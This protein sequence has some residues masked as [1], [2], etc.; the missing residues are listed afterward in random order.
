MRTWF[1]AVVLA[2]FCAP[3]F[4]QTIA[5]GHVIGNGTSAARSATDSTMTGIFD[6]AF[7]ATNTNF[8]YRSSGTWQCA[9]TLP[10]SQITG[11]PSFVN[12]T[13]TTPGAV[14]TLTLTNTPIP[15]D[16]KQLSIYF[17]GVTQHPS[18]WS[19]NLGNG[20]ITFNTTIPTSVQEVFAAWSAPI[21][22]VG[23]SSLGSLTGAV[24]AGLGLTAKSGDN[25]I[26][27]QGAVTINV[28]LPPYNAVDD[29]STN[30]TTAFQNAITDAA[31]SGGPA[32]I[33]IPPVTSGGGCYKVGAI[34]ATKKSNL[35]IRGNGDASLLEPV[36]SSATNHIWWDISG[37]TNVTFENF[38]VQYDGATVPAILFL[39]AAV[40]GFTGD[41]I[42]GIRFRQVN[43][44]AQASTALVYVY[45]VSWPGGTHLG[46]G[47]FQCYDSTWVQRKNGSFNSNPSLRNS[48][49]SLNGINSASVASDYQTLTV[50]QPGNNS[51]LLE[52]CNL[53]DSPSGFGSGVTDNNAALIAVTTGV[54]VANSGSVQCVCTM[55]SVFYTNNEGF[56]F[57]NTAFVAPDGSV[58]VQYWN[59]FGGGANGEFT[60]NG[61]FW[62]V[63]TVNFIGWD[64]A[65]GGVGG[66]SHWNVISPDVG[67][68]P[69]A[70]NFAQTT[71]ACSVP[72]ATTW[73]ATS[74]LE[75]ADG[76]NN[77]Q[78][79]GNI[80]SHTIIQNPG[81]VALPGGAV[82][83]SHH[84]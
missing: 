75:L 11:V 63:P 25:S 41:V 58:T 49:L 48:V 9:A 47:G 72:A 56:T 16:K 29:C 18:T 55:D 21:T 71:F 67:G 70:L 10:Y 31:A 54:F 68:N 13:F 84:F 12:Q 50:L 61:V 30:N 22:S 43:M 27:S 77:I 40:N 76:A 81:T 78:A 79:C 6:Q 38:K 20:V 2:L 62:S 24:A 19:I 44:D 1:Y 26:N 17:D 74:K 53:I 3:A 39:V 60:M 23:V 8:V 7:C 15:T 35:I 45:A 65:V 66:I 51:I 42:S 14:S 28:K 57:N 52:N 69:G 36:A 64:P 32:V 82:D 34:N 59:V 4:A 83:S 73:I 33:Y 80:D 5:P 37:S 46:A